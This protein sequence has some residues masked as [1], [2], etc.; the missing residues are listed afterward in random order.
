MPDNS[1]VI[2]YDRNMFKI[3]AIGQL[4][5][6]VR[7]KDIT[8]LSLCRKSLFLVS[9]VIYCY[10]ESRDARPMAGKRIVDDLLML[11]DTAK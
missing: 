5:G 2:I 10:A 9:R 3:Q 11:A 7:G 6:L 8:T 1:R 4:D